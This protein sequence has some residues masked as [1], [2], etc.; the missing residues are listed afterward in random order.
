MYWDE[1]FPILLC[2]SLVIQEHP[3]PPRPRG[4]R[5]A[6]PDIWRRSSCLFVYLLTVVRG[7]QRIDG[8]ESSWCLPSEIAAES[9]LVAGIRD[10]GKAKKWKKRDCWEAENFST[11][12]MHWEP[13]ARH[14]DIKLNS[15]CGN[16]S[17]VWRFQWWKEWQLNTQDIIQHHIF[18]CTVLWAGYISNILPAKSLVPNAQPTR[19]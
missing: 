15:G 12:T 10:R 8:E 1:K 17:P 18:S 6:T 3:V 2:V 14:K 11:E 5:G 19:L 13:K 4:A 7:A 16:K 9:K